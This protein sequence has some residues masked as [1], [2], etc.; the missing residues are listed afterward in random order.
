M[1]VR[2]LGA[3]AVLVVLEYSPTSDPSRAHKRKSQSHIGGPPTSQQR[4]G[5][6]LTAADVELLNVADRLRRADA[7]AVLPP[8]PNRRC[9]TTCAASLLE[10]ASVLTAR[11]TPKRSTACGVW[12]A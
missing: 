8:R 4:A 10:A 2:R 3:H 9:S 6:E 5:D 12:L 11:L 1:P 7:P